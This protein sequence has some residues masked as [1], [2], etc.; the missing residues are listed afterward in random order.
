MLDEKNNDLMQKILR[1]NF[2]V[3]P[4]INKKI[5]VR[6]FLKQILK[7]D[8]K[9]TTYYKNFIK[10][11][12]P[13]IVITFID[14]NKFFYTLKDKF[15]DIK[16]IAIQNGNRKITSPFFKKNYLKI[17]KCDH[18]FLFNHYLI[19]EYK[20]I[21]K[22]QYHV[23]GSYKN[24]MVSIKKTEFKKSFLYISQYL[25]SYKLHKNF[26]L[27]FLALIDKFFFEN[28]L[29][30]NILLRSKKFS[31]IED[32]K[33]FY[34][35]NFKSNCIFHKSD[36]NWRESYRIVDKFDTIIFIDSTL[37]YEAISRKKKVAIFS[38]KTLEN[39]KEKFGWPANIKKK[40][41]FFLA[42][43]LS[44]NEIKRVL[45]NVYN[46]RQSYWEK[47]YYA[48]IKNQIHIDKNNS[49]IKDLIIKI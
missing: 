16:F 11:V 2:I 46:C 34:R 22:S 19:K 39:K 36:T 20:K 7:L 33:N 26:I 12:S 40:Y 13:K 47:K 45:T 28:N 38:L 17:L 6:V 27:N 44:Y 41:Y 21:I 18:I 25:K 5:Y 37:G 30:I 8:F 14:N 24:N 32:E 23:L 3:L 35:K 29:E 43:E 9:Y 31:D 42:K 1:Q 48:C 4:S 10:H 49:K 15:K